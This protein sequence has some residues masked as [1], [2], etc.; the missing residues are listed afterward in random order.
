LKGTNRYKEAYKT[1][2]QTKYNYKDAKVSVIGHSLGG[3]IAQ[4]TKKQG[5]ELYALDSVYNWAKKL[6]TIMVKVIN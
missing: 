1:L 3:T 4:G 2:R 5:D 6:E